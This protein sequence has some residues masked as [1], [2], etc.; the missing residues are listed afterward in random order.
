MRRDY[1][2]KEKITTRLEQLMN[3]LKLDSLYLKVYPD[4]ERG[5]HVYEKVGFIKDSEV[6]D[7]ED[8]ILFIDVKLGIIDVEELIYHAIQLEEP[9]VKHCEKCAALP[10]EEEDEEENDWL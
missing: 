9:F 3:E 4:N 5:I 7:D 8:E 2:D 1:A 10:V 6:K